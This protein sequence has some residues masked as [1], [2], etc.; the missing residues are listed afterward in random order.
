MEI[1]GGDEDVHKRCESL[2]PETPPELQL[3]P[4]PIEV[5]VA[6]TASASFPPLVGPIAFRVGNDLEYW[7]TGD[8]GFYENLGLETLMFTFQM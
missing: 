4:C 6:M 8:G 3:D 5:A 2:L 1:I 7:H